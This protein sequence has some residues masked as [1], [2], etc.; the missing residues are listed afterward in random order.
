MGIKIIHEM[1]SIFLIGSKS[2]KSGVQ[3][4]LRAYLNLDQLH[5]KSSVATWHLNSRE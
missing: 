2:L 3:L 1:Y 4:T 5:F